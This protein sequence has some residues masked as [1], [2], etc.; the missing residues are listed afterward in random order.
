METDTTRLSRR[1]LLKL[2]A[3]GFG[4]VALTA[5]GL[6]VPRGL[7]SGSGGGSVYLEAFPTSPLILKPFSDPLPV[8][9]ALAPIAKS[10]VDG[11]SSPPAPNKA[12]SL[13]LR[14]DT[15]YTRKYG[16]TLGT[17]QIW[18]STTP[19]VYQIKLQV[20]GHDFTSSQVQPINSFGANVIPPGS[21]DSR[22]RYLP[23][24]TIYGFNGKFPGPLINAEY[25][26]PVW[27]VRQPPRPEPP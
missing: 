11:W 2:G 14:S 13:P 16:P 19:Q 3:G 27:S 18:P 1:D 5:S 7:A 10:V 17:H 22:P 12:D 20:A 8:P 9:T 4:M 26:K 23:Q 24:S 6:V 25:G 15:I 21:S